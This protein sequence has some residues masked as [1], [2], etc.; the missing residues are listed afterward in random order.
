M[1][2]TDNVRRSDVENKSKITA[3]LILFLIDSVNK[4]IASARHQGT[5]QRDAPSRPPDFF[6]L[7]IH[8]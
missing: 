6:F 8:I 5:V 2:K 1:A 7:L 4:V 3:F